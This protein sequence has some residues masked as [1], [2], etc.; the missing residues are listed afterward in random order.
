[1]LFVGDEI[2][3][4]TVEYVA[5]ARSTAVAVVRLRAANRPMWLR[6]IAKKVKETNQRPTTNDS[7]H[8]ISNSI[9]TFDVFTCVDILTF[10]VPRRGPPWSSIYIPE[11]KSADY[12]SLTTILLRMGG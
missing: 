1:M 4:D 3:E 7:Q 11:P 6:T 12:E 10:I 5:V 2:D 8:L 9:I